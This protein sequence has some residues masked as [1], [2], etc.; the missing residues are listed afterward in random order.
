MSVTFFF[1]KVR[2][3]FG[4]GGRAGATA[5]S[6]PRATSRAAG[7]LAILR[8]PA[9]RRRSGCLGSCACGSR[10]RRRSADRRSARVRAS[11]PEWRGGRWSKNGSPRR[12][13]RSRDHWRA[14]GTRT[15]DP[16]VRSPKG[17]QE[18]TR[19]CVSLFCRGRHGAAPATATA[20][21]RHHQEC[22][23]GCRA[24]AAESPCEPPMPGGGLRTAA[25]SMQRLT[26][27]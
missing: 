23:E 5:Q 25:L 14:G 7:R 9:R 16:Q 4:N 2:R 3:H 24:V 1:L 27:T 26:P 10:R 22:V 6:H 17:P 12:R 20:S 11:P 15:P 8:A 13:A 19:G 18:M 21:P